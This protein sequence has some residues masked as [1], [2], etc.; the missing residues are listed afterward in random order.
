MCFF[1]SVQNKSAALQDQQ[2]E[3]TVVTEPEVSSSTMG[4]EDNKSASLGGNLYLFIS[5]ISITQLMFMCRAAQW[6]SV[7]LYQRHF[8]KMHKTKT[9]RREIISVLISR[10]SNFLKH[11][12]TLGLFFSARRRRSLQNRR[13]QTD[14]KLQPKH[15]L[16]QR[17]K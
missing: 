3:R 7:Y 14:G 13:W 4:R 15:T 1:F 12:R 5:L 16:H 10:H 17:R 6:S 11:L 8:N 2:S 9:S